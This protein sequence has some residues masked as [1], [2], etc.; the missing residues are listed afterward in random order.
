MTKRFVLYALTVLILATTITYL[1]NPDLKSVLDGV[2]ARRS[3]RLEDVTGLVKVR[4]YVINNGFVV[5]L[6]MLL[7]ACIPVPF[8]YIIQITATAALP[9]VLFGLILRYDSHEA[10]A[11]IASSLP[12]AVLELSGLCLFASLL[13]RL[14]TSICQFCWQKLLKRQPEYCF[15]EE[16]MN[17]FKNYFLLVLPLIITAAFT[18]EYVSD[19]IYRL[20]H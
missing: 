12:H 7:F 13:Y 6:Q 2:S 3:E 9:G 4:E 1:I 20:L 16:L 15:K 10:F 18:E 11:I 17:L 19:S 8:L 5:P 14:N